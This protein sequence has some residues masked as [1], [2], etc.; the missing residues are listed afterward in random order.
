MQMDSDD[1]GLWYFSKK[2][3]AEE[4]IGAKKKKRVLKFEEQGIAIINQFH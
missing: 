4:F 3:T 2:A 1:E